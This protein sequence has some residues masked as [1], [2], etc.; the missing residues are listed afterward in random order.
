MQVTLEHGRLHTHTRGAP[1]NPLIPESATR[2]CVH[3]RGAD[4]IAELEFGHD[5]SGA[6][7]V[8]VSQRSASQKV[9][10]T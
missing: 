9:E 8:V 5:V 2:V 6:A 3:D 7:G 4:D 1:Q 10:R